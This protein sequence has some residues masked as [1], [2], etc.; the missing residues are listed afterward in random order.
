MK[1][2]TSIADHYE[3]IFPYKEFKVDFIDSFLKTKSDVLDIGCALGDI[4]N[5]LS[6]KGHK[7]LGIDLDTRMIEIAKKRHDSNERLSFKVM[8][9]TKIQSDL[10]FDAVVSTGNT[11]VHLEDLTD[12]K[13]FFVSLRNNLVDNGVVFFQILNY[14]Y[15]LK[16]RIEELPLI[17]NDKIRFIRKYKFEEEKVFFKTELTIKEED[18]KVENL[19]ELYPLTKNNIVEILSE[20]GYKDVEFYSDMKGTVY[21]KDSLPL[22][23]KAVKE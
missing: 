18:H 20:T 10:V 3:H 22:I 17:E 21:K 7:V 13:K 8:D 16:N 2:Y 5:G 1:F 19:I 12:I 23:F 14:E 9:M 6:L 4:S 11:L 15:I